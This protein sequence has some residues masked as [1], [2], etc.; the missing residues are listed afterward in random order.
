MLPLSQRG[1]LHRATGCWTALV[2]SSTYRARVAVTDADVT[3]GRGE[4]GEPSEAATSGSPVAQTT[5][6]WDRAGG[7]ASNLIC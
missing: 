6:K 1:L 7:A 2:G 5:A 4:L 3:G